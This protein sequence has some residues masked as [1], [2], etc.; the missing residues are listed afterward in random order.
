MRRASPRI[1]RPLGGSP[2]SAS[3]SH[4]LL[5]VP[6]PRPRPVP[7]GTEHAHS[8]FLPHRDITASVY[9][10]RRFPCPSLRSALRLSQPLDGFLRLRL[11][12]LVPSRGHVQGSTVQGFLPSRSDSPSSGLS[13]PLSLG[14]RSLPLR[15]PRPGSLGFEASFRAK[16]HAGKAALT[17]SRLL[18]SSAFRP[19]SGFLPL[20]FGP[21]YPSH[22]LSTLADR[23]SLSR[24][25]NRVVH[26]VLPAKRSAALF[27]EC[28]PA[29]GFEPSVT[30]GGGEAPTRQV[31]IPSTAG[32]RRG[33]AVNVPRPR[34]LDAASR[35]RGDA[36]SWPVDDPVTGE[37]PVT[38]RYRPR[39]TLESGRSGRNGAR[40]RGPMRRP[41]QGDRSG[42]AP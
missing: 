2:G 20:R 25:S 10:M 27:P 1:D 33:T 18:P 36:A 30:Y 22:P 6:S 11:R 24:P 28:R 41:L 35:N 3:L 38:I 14:R 9:T 16:T 42:G 15:A 8:G 26:S 12:G 40:R 23:C 5:G 4:L 37:H 34:R 39:R 21:G 19:P 32:R 17:Q 7:F 31:A 13:A 29:R